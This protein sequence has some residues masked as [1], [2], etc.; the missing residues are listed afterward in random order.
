MNTLVVYESMWGN[1]RAVAEA[2]ADPLGED[3]TLVDVNDAPEELPDDLENRARTHDDPPP[4]CGDGSS[5]R[6]A[7]YVRRPVP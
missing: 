2:V 7:R 1:T 4:R 3:V 6:A 5:G